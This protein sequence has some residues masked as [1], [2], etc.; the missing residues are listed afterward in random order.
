MLYAT[1]AHS[2]E[3]L[4]QIL[5]LQQENHIENIDGNEMQSQGFVTLRHDFETLNQ[6][7]E[8]AASVI[9]KD[10]DKVV[11]YAL[12]MLRECRQLIPDLEPMFALFDKLDWLNHPLNNY[13]FY[14]MGQVCVAKAYRGKGLFEQLYAHHR[15]TYQS[16]F[17]LLLT[18][19]STRNHRSLRAHEKTGFK[20]IHTHRDN[21]DEWQVVGW[22]W[23]GGISNKEHGTRNR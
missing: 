9:I 12:T 13:R 8:L 21:L 10:D 23:S 4:K 2:R 14:V 15:K 16:Q 20:I 1:L 6:M 22:D 5:Q 3:E 19:I 7:H 11:A 18:E 17:D